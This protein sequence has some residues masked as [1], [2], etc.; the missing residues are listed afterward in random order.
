MDNAATTTFESNGATFKAIAYKGQI[1]LYDL[2]VWASEGI[3]RFV[4][5]ISTNE[6]TVQS[7]SALALAVLL[8]NG[9]EIEFSCAGTTQVC[10]KAEGK[11]R[12]LISGESIIKN[13][14]CTYECALNDIIG[15]IYC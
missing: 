14:E 3:E 10:D 11:S 12:Y 1:E 13:G 9:Y 15:M 6:L 2:T 5:Y 4:G 7:R 8:A